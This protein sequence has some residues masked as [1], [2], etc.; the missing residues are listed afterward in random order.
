[1]YLYL[2]FFNY[3]ILRLKKHIGIATTKFSNYYL[4]LNFRYNNTLFTTLRLVSHLLNKNLLFTSPGMFIKFFQK[5]KSLKK[6]KLTKFLTIK[7]IRKLLV[8]AKI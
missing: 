5:K 3:S 7:F 1:M 6:H 4:L 2:N 8:I